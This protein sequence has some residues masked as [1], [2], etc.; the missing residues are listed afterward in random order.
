[1]SDQFI[2]IEKSTM[3]A[4]RQ[5]LLSNPRIFQGITINGLHHILYSLWLV[6]EKDLPEIENGN[7]AMTGFQVEAAVSDYLYKL[8]GIPVDE[9]TAFKPAKK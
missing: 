4:V 8:T 9:W 2:V 1:M 3:V 7:H 6:D 5:A